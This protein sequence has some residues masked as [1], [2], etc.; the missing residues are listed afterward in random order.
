MIGRPRLFVEME[1]LTLG[2]LLMTERT[3]SMTSSLLA[4]DS[5]NLIVFR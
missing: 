3:L 5:V 1:G 2:K 4:V